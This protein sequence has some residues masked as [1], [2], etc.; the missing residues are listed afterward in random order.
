MSCD[1]RLNRQSVLCDLEHH[2]LSMETDIEECSSHAVEY[3][4]PNV[5]RTLFVGDPLLVMAM[6]LRAVSWGLSSSSSS[7]VA[8]HG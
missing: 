6:L 8:L 4:Q 1:I 3:R 2:T 5:E 7:F